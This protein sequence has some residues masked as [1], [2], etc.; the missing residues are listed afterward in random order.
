MILDTGMLLMAQYS[1]KAVIPVEDVCRDYFSHLTPD[2]F[3][4]QALR[5]DIQLPV[6]RMTE[7]QKSAKGVALQDLADFLDKRRAAAKKELLQ[8]TGS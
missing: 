4:R 7:S 2:Q 6:V 8:M 5:G 1:G 3:L